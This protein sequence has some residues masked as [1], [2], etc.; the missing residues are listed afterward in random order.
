MSRSKLHARKHRKRRRRQQLADLRTADLRVAR[1]LAESR[2][3]PLA[4]CR[5]AYLVRDHWLREKQ[6]AAYARLSA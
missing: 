2:E 6:A 5:A 1:R 4:E 3:V